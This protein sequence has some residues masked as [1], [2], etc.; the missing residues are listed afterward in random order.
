MTQT[1]DNESLDIHSL[2]AI[3]SLDVRAL[4]AY[5]DMCK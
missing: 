2:I 4:R 3:E 1:I 5:A